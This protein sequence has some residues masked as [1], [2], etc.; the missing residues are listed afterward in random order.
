MKIEH[1]PKGIFLIQTENPQEEKVFEAFKDEVIA[2]L[3]RLREIWEKDLVVL[4]KF[5][6]IT[7]LKGATITFPEKP[8]I[9]DI[10]DKGT[11]LLIQ[12]KKSYGRPMDQR[13]LL[14]SMRLLLGAPY[15]RVL[16]HEKERRIKEYYSKL[17]DKSVISEQKKARHKASQHPAPQICGLC[18]RGSLRFCRQPDDLRRP[19]SL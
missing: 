2:Y 14:A 1:D 3:P 4:S 10:Y 17:R 5:T 12:L 8:S 16:A 9:L 11:P 7:T 18:G 15:K 13:T 19:R 6:D